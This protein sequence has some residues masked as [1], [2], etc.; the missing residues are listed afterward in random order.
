[1]AGMRCGVSTVGVVAGSRS[2]WKTIL[3]WSLVAG[4]G[5]TTWRGACLL[6]ILRVTHWYWMARWR[7][8][9][10]SFV[11][12]AVDRLGYQVPSTP[13]F[14]NDVYPILQRAIQYQW[15]T[16]KIGNKH[17]PLQVVI[18]PPATS[19]QRNMV[20]QQLRDPATTPTVDTP[21]LMP[22]IWTDYFAEVFGI[23]GHGSPK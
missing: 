14:T 15:V 7:M 17:V 5:M 21:H 20:F 10:T 3:R 2:C 9:Y 23:R 4:G 18:P 1:M 8:G 19:D 11:N 22:A 16:R 12:D 13:S 6:P